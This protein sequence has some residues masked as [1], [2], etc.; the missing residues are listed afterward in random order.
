MRR[1][2]EGGGQPVRAGGQ[3]GDAVAGRGRVQRCLD[4]RRVIGLAVTDGPKAPRIDYSPHAGVRV[5]LLCA[6]GREAPR[7]ES[8]CSHARE[9]RHRDPSAGRR[10]LVLLVG[11]ALRGGAPPEEPPAQVT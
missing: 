4:G 2:G 10:G 1:Y 9:T 3:E 5:R 11:P 7:R 8:H 6:H